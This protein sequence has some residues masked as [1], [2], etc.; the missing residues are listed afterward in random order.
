MLWLASVVGATFAAQ[1][2]YTQK[3]RNELSDIVYERCLVKQSQSELNTQFLPGVVQELCKC[4]AEQVTTDIL[5]SVEFQLAMSRDDN[6]AL[7]II[8]SRK[9][10]PEILAQTS[11]VC[12]DETIKKRGGLSKVVRGDPLTKLSTQAGLKGD[13]RSDYVASGVIKCKSAQRQM[14]DNKGISDDVIDSYCNCAFNYTA[15]RISSA[16]MAAILIQQSAG[17]KLRDKLTKESAIFCT[18]KILE[19]KSK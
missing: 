2:I 11:M 1:E 16:D 19:I 4:V 6:A 10:A 18:Q 7:K 5:G 13:S 3:Q 14:V 12:A 8:I 15:D 9:M 17:I